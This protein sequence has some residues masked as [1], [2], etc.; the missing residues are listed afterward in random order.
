MRI[1]THFQNIENTEAKILSHG[2]NCVHVL[3]HMAIFKSPSRK[4][5]D[6]ETWLLYAIVADPAP[7]P[8][9]NK[10]LPSLYWNFVMFYKVP[11]YSLTFLF[12]YFIHELKS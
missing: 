3:A 10:F 6:K 2:V 11:A 8:H 1:V 7:D 9:L 5:S 12:I 4:C